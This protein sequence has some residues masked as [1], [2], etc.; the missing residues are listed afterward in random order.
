MALPAK[1]CVGKIIEPALSPTIEG[2]TGSHP[3]TF[4]LEWTLLFPPV[5]I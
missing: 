5:P 4:D 2:V 1:K 3:N